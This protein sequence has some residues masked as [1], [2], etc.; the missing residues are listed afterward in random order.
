MPRVQSATLLPLNS[1]RI[2]TVEL[3]CAL[4][5]THTWSSSVTRVPVESGADRAQHIVDNPYVL[6][7]EAV[8]SEIPMDPTRQSQQIA[9]SIAQS[10]GQGYLDSDPGI[11]AARNQ[12]WDRFQGQANKAKT[13][14]PFDPSR[15]V[16]V[17]ASLQAVAFPRAQYS[18]SDRFKVA[19]SRLLALRSSRTPFDYVS[20]LG[21]VEN[22]VFEDLEI[23]VDATSDLLFRARLVEFVE[24]G[25]TRTN[26]LAISQRD[27]SSDAANIGS[28][29][30]IDA[31]FQALL[32]S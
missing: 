12:N 11:V 13:A 16:S 3:D 26:S 27:A 14:G 7:I 4:N 30:T 1:V 21:L 22:L 2:G 32:A 25:L 24:V 31:E 28:R 5:E 19:L 20:P 23:P 29:T 6:V 10:A 9:L 8:I 17:A 18:A 15:A